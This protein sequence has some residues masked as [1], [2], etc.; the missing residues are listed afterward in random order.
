MATAH[1]NTLT[2]TKLYYLLL[3]CCKKL[4]G[5]SHLPESKLSLN[6]PH[7]YSFLPILTNISCWKVLTAYRRYTL[8]K[9]DLNFLKSYI[10]FI[11]L[12]IDQTLLMVNLV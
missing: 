9:L 3:D 12:Q 6:S 8:S 2:W 1:L 5:A 7:P 11:Q 10:I 4:S